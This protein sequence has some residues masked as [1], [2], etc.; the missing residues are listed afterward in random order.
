MACDD[1]LIEILD[2]NAIDSTKPDF[3][4]K[5][6]SIRFPELLFLQIVNEWGSSFGTH[7][8]DCFLVSR[9]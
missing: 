8:F 2:S 7:V 9:S 1:A 4:K 5:I 6:V 3:M